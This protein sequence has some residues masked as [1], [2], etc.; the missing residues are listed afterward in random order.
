MHRRGGHKQQHTTLCGIENTVRHTKGIAAEQRIAQ[1][2][3]NAHMMQRMPRRIE[4]GKGTA[5]KIQ[6]KT[7][8]RLNHPLSGHRN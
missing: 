6:H 1:R 7:L 4:K 3:V 5:I 2:I 8:G